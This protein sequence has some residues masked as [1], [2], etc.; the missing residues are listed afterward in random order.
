MIDPN[1]NPWT[2]LSEKKI[3]N[4][5]WIELTEFDVLNPQG[6][7]GI[8]SV[9]HFHNLAIGILPL[10]EENNTWLVGQYRFPLKHY[11]WEI[12]E[13]GGKKNIPPIESAKRELLE[14]TGIEAQEWIPIIETHLSNS[15]M[16]E[17]GIIYIAKGLSFQKSS[18]EET[19]ELQVKKIAFEEVYKMVLNGE[20]NDSLSMLAVMKTKLLMIEGK[21]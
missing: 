21:L 9:V 1:K 18:P 16:D 11:S 14:E 12:P 4:N 19:E 7:K 13:G 15:A 10:D 3:Y 8:Y 5:P 17:F 6:G 2:I 20:I